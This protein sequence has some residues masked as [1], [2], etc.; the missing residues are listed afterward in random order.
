LRRG[1]ERIGGVKGRAATGRATIRCED[2]VL[3]I[4][5]EEI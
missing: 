5:K 2:Q 1:G 4:G 3:A